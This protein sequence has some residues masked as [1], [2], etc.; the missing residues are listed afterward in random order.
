MC[1][2]IQL[3]SENAEMGKDVELGIEVKLEILYS[4]ELL[5]REMLEL[6]VD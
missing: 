6:S 3:C 4:W 5:A 2:L 1:T